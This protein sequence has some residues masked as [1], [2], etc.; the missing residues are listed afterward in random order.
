MLPAG[1]AEEIVKQ[2]MNRYKNNLNYDSVSG[3]ISSSQHIQALTEDFWFF[4]KRR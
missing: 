1:K 2:T 4:S 3:T